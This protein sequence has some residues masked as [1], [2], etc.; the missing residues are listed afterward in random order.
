MLNKGDIEQQL[1][2]GSWDYQEGKQFNS[3]L[4][5]IMHFGVF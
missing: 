2:H 3:L 1:Y 4:Y 5:Q